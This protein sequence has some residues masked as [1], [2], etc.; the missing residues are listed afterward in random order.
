MRLLWRFRTTPT[1]TDFGTLGD[2]LLTAYID[3]AG[4]LYARTGLDNDDD[5]P[6]DV[7]IG[8]WSDKWVHIG[9]SI[10]QTR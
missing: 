4:T 8:T 7:V 10:S 9:I 1:G 6:C 5:F 2:R 3:E